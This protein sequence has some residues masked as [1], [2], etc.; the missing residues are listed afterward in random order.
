[1]VPESNGTGAISWASGTAEMGEFLR[2]L[3]NSWSFSEHLLPRLEY[4]RVLDHHRYEL[5]GPLPSAVPGEGE[6]QQLKRRINPEVV[7]ELQ[8]ALRD[9]DIRIKELQQ[10]W[11]WRIT[12]PVR[13]IAGVMLRLFR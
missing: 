7:E 5:Q 2:G 6:S 8:T 10:S 9:R 11:S 1:M 12:A 3:F 13:A 4:M